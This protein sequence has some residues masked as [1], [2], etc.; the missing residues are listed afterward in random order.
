MYG[1][2]FILQPDPSDA[3][4]MI[5]RAT[6]SDFQRQSCPS[7]HRQANGNKTNHHSL[8]QSSTDYRAREFRV[9]QRE[10]LLHANRKY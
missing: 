6:H 10:M 9:L 3:P 8:N 4:A 7:S 2:N 5:A 1:R